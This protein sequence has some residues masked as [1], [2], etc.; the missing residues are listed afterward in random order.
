MRLG[1]N[2][3]AIG[4]TAAWWLESARRLDAAG[5]DAVWCWDHFLSR[6]DPTDPVLECWTTL[7]AAAAVT[8]R[9]HVGSFVTNV[10]NRHPAVLARMA[11]TAQDVAQGRL[12]MGIAIGGFPREHHALGIPFP[13]PAERAEH[14]EEAVQVL[15]LLWSGG[16]VSF[17]GRHYALTDAVAHPVPDPAPRLIIAGETTAGARL[18][19]RLGDAWATDTT[20]LTRDRPAFLEAL[21]ETGRRPADVPVLVDV[22][23]DRHRP[24][25]D[26]AVVADLAGELARWAD[27]GASE[28]VIGYV[29]PD[30]LDAVIAARARLGVG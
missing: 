15:R 22:E 27:A 17:R 12:E 25:A 19:A 4:V 8:G 20:G 11:A 5:F 1:V 10:M 28:L 2:L 9:I 16:P 6:G 30:Q 13:S 26:Q 21:A 29:R 7:A 3:T 14:L 18:A 23:L 24:A